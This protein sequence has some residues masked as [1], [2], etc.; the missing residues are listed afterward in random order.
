MS[1]SRTALRLAEALSRKSRNGSSTAAFGG[2]PLAWRMT[3]RASASASENVPSGVV[4]PTRDS[5]IRIES[6]S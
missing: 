4:W 5:R 3:A 6:A 2:R 1:G